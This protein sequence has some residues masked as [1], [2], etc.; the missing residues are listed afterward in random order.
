MI[1]IGI[2]LASDSVLNVVSSI[3]SSGKT[4]ISEINVMA[5]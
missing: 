5:T 1:W 3:H 2:D 4:K